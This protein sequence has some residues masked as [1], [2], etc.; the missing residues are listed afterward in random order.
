VVSALARKEQ[1]SESEF[2]HFLEIVILQANTDTATITL[3]R[4]SERGPA[5]CSGRDGSEI[6][7]PAD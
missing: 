1:G 5:S 3:P 6:F 2:R 7:R 4:L